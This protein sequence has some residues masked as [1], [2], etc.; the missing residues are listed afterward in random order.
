MSNPREIELWLKM[1]RRGAGQP[2]RQPKSALT[3]LKQSFESFGLQTR[4]L[5]LGQLLLCLT[6]S[7]GCAGNLPGVSRQPP[8]TCSVPADLLIQAV[9]PPMQDATNADLLKEAGEL[10]AALRLCSKDKELIQKYLEERG[11]K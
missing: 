6:V 10:R 1:R 4:L 7:V 3:R 5:E 11:K 8:S 2:R 9:E